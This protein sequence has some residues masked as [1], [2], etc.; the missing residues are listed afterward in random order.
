MVFSTSQSNYVYIMIR[1]K[2]SENLNGIVVSLRC[3]YG[4]TDDAFLIGGLVGH[5][6]TLTASVI[7]H[8]KR[9]VSFSPGPNQRFYL[10]KV[11]DGLVNHEPVKIYIYVIDVLY[12]NLHWRARNH[13]PRMATLIV[14]HL[15]EIQAS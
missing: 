13:T 9:L 3:H 11:I 14:D 10:A 7:R 1:L 8:C 6:E 15:N 5:E 12:N 2:M 4:E